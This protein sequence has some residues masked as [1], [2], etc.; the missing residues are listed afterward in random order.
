M[1]KE[2]CSEEKGL[3]LLHQ[4][5]DMLE[6]DPLIDELGYIHP[7]QFSLLND[8]LG[9]CCD[10]SEEVLHPSTKRTA[11]SVESLVD[12]SNRENLYFWN[13]DHKLGIST[14]ILLQLYGSAKH[15]FMSAFKQYK[16]SSNQSDKVGTSSHVLL[17][18]D[19]LESILMRHSRSLLLLSC[20][21]ITAWN[22]RKH[23]LS[24]KNQFSMFMDELH[25]SALVLSYA[26]KSEQAWSHRRWVIKSISANCSNFNEILEKESELVEKIAERSKMNYR[27]WNHR[28][29]LV[30][31]MKMEQALH[32]L[33]RTRNWAALH[34][35]DNCCFHYRRRLLVKI[36]EDSSCM[37]GVSSGHKSDIDQLWKD[38]ID[39][40]RTLIKRYVG[41]EALWL[42]RRFL[43]LCWINHFLAD[44]SDISN[45]SK[46]TASRYH[47]FGKFLENELCL[48]KSCSTIVD[49]DFEDL[50]SQVKHSACYIL[51]LK[52]ERHQQIHQRSQ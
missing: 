52:M 11:G 8:E 28:C 26:P 25:L 23:V 36:L 22:C 4:L 39:W 48:F 9:I 2:S 45:P 47:E 19:H 38:E 3:N 32:E 43:S 17:S 13:R 41:R 7:S 46:E 18:C 5:E 35:A 14:Q 29:W 31:H 15:A 33:E 6:N 37:R 34:V 42:H 16:A 21:F 27:A 20:D 30:S 1:S 50:Q 44:S 51:W 10:S 40:N 49:N 24:K 12:T